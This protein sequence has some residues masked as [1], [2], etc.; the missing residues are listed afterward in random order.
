MIFQPYQLHYVDVGTPD[1]DNSDLALTKT[2]NHHFNSEE[3]DENS[4]MSAALN[5]Q[6][7]CL[8]TYMYIR[9]SLASYCRRCYS[10]Y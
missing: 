1:N 5:Q 4:L 10:I 6:P 8:H 3:M 7:T 9:I 2:I